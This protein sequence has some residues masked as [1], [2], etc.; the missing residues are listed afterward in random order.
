MAERKPELIKKE[1]ERGAR[2]QSGRMT[3]S[4]P[5][6]HGQAKVIQM[7][8]PDQRQPMN[9]P[10]KKNVAQTTSTTG[11]R[12]NPSVTGPLEEGHK[13]LSDDSMFNS[14]DPQA[15]N[16]NP[17]SHQPGTEGPDKP[18]QKKNKDRKIV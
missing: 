16:M 6:P 11:N 9:K 1:E 3:E 17:A 4:S 15:R 12:M 14:A 8:H 7:P 18:G 5:N 2:G 10:M 13:G